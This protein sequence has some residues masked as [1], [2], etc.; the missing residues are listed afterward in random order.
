MRGC[1]D[2]ID[3]NSNR[4]TSEMLPVNEIAENL[5][6]SSCFLV[7]CLEGKTDRM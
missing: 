2:K 4:T 3:R 1:T 6:T 5:E 7:A